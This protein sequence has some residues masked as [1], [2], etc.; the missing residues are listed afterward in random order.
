M[1]KADSVHLFNSSIE[2]TCN[3]AGDAALAMGFGGT[4]IFLTGG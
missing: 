3:R 2:R 1:A 4:A